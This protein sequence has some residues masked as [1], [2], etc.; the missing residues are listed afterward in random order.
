MGACCIAEVDCKKQFGN[1]NPKHVVCCIAEAASWLYHK[2][3]WRASEVVWSIHHQL[4]KLNRPC[5]AN[6]D[7]FWHMPNDL[8]ER[9]WR[10]E[11]L[12]NTVLQAVGKLLCRVTSIPMGGL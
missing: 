1:I 5:V 7:K 6:N 4:S 10:F 9:L 11:L 8:L 3:S 12:Q 2:R